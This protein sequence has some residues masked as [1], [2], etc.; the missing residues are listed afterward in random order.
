MS[1]TPRCWGQS[2]AVEIKQ[3]MRSAWQRTH[4][5]M[6]MVFPTFVLDL[7]LHLKNQVCLSFQGAADHWNSSPDAYWEAPRMNEP[8]RWTRSHQ[9]PWG[10]NWGGTESTFW[11]VHIQNLV[12][13][14]CPTRERR[15][16]LCALGA[17]WARL[18]V[19]WFMGVSPEL[20]TSISFPG[21]SGGLFWY[22]YWGSVGKETS[23]LEPSREACCSFPS[24]SLHEDTNKVLFDM[25]FWW[26]RQAWLNKLCWP[27][28]EP[29]AGVC[30]VLGTGVM[31]TPS[32]LL[33]VLKGWQEDSSCQG[34]STR[35]YL[36][37]R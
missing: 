32:L 15:D 18:W 5:A 11:G 3:G 36:G 21:K 37:S 27:L 28:A 4:Q 9:P 12:I 30:A 22:C 10:G 33:A 19:N 29:G 6:A 1:G 8:G 14:F 17:R 24:L 20:W 34:D 16:V 13:L 31:L 35:R 25:N 26:L 23:I 7:G 2:E